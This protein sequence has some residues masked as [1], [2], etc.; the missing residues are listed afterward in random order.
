MSRLSEIALVVWD[1]VKLLW[2]PA[3]A[4]KVCLG[5]GMAVWGMKAAMT[6]YQ[7]A[8]VDMGRCIDAEMQPHTSGDGLKPC[9]DRYINAHYRLGGAALEL[10]KELIPLTARMR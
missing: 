4:I 7:A 8:S 10:N 3:M 9:F 1:L 2:K 5:V 6:E